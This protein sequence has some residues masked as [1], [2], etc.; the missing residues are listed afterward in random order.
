MTPLRFLP[1][2][3]S[4]PLSA[5]AVFTATLTLPH[6]RS[7]HPSIA[8]LTPLCVINNYEQT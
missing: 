7:A 5:G 3:M 4:P 1:Q 8:I 2:I 6:F